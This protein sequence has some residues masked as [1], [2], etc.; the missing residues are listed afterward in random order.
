P[1]APRH[2][3]V[4]DGA[5]VAERARTDERVSEDLPHGRRLGAQ[6]GLG[7]LGQARLPEAL[8]HV[9]AIF[10][11]DRAFVEAERDEREPEDRD[12]AQVGQPRRAGEDALDL[13][14]DL[15]LDA[16][17]RLLREERD[18][19]DHRVG[20]VGVGLD[21]QRAERAPGDEGERRRAPE[22][23]LPVQ[24]AEPCE[25]GEHRMAQRRTSSSPSRS[26]APSTTTSSP[27]DTPST[28]CTWSPSWRP[29]STWRRSST[30]SA[31]RTKTT[32]SSRRRRSAERG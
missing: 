24:G 21:G 5:E 17:G 3:P 18:D 13:E 10:A 22:D 6:H 12:R 31:T 26:T 30:F 15:A 27:A 1:E 29:S 28:I 7:A 32:G 2:R 11:I 23:E 19:L 14:R 20:D 4:L 25:R 8:G 9:G 16:L